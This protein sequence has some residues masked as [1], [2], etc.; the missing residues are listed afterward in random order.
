[1]KNLFILL[2]GILLISSCVPE[3]INYSIKGKIIGAE[4]K[5][6]KYIDMTSPGFVIDSLLLDMGGNF[7]FKK[8]SSVPGDYIFYYHKKNHIR[9]TPCPNEQIKLTANANNLA[10]SYQ[11][12][13][14]PESVLVSKIIKRNFKSSNIIDT[15]NDFYMKNQMHPNLDSIVNL[16][17][18]SSDSIFS[19]D[20]KY[21]ENFIEKNSNSLASYVIL[22]QKLANDYPFF[23][24]ANDLKYF[25]M[26]DTALFNRYD[27]IPMAKMLNMYVLQQKSNLKRKQLEQK[28]NLMGK[29]APEIYLPN[30]YGDSLK[31]S[32]IHNKYILVDFWGTWCRQSRI[33]NKNLRTA[34]IKYRYKGFEIFQVAIEREKTDWKN[35][36]REDR[37]YWK[38]QVS[39][40]NYMKSQTAKD[41][42]VKEI[43]SN[44]LIDPQGNVIAMNLYGEK[45]IEK[46]EEVFTP[47]PVVENLN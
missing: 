20:K 7:T 18:R 26:V 27:T 4:G 8:E 2:I 28:D 37:L 42:L 45:L 23:T 33:E 34:Y 3:P 24:L 6:I 44:F 13:G 19:A 14:S 15:L 16:L 41:Y 36:L 5:Y 43:P 21:Y 25:E 38:Y 12:E 35:T 17:M 32:S 39:E 30:V 11:V 9:I 1:M 22:S 29:K 10:E 31:L 46:L 40:L 47:Q